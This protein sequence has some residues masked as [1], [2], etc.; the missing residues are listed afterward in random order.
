MNLGL[1][2]S[3]TVGPFFSDALT[4]LD[5][6]DVVPDPTPGAFW[7]RSVVASARAPSSGAARPPALTVRPRVTPLAQ[8]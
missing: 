8:S 5:G 2:P 6:P 3:Q 4:W 7:L 1:T